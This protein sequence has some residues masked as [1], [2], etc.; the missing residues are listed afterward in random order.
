MIFQNLAGIAAWWA[1]DAK[2][3]HDE[4]LLQMAHNLAQM[5]LTEEQRAEVL[6]DAARWMEEVRQRG[7]AQAEKIERCGG[8]VDETLN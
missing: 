8:R 3:R 5:D 6:A 4:F 2:R 1:K 7:I